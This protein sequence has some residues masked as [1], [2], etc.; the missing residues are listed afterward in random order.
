M[1]LELVKGG[2]ARMAS[3]VCGRVD[4]RSL[5]CSVLLG[6]F[7]SAASAV[8]ILGGRIWPAPDHTRLV[9]DLSAAT[10]YKV[11]TLS[12]PDRV[13]IDV[14]GAQL[15]GRL[16]LDGLEK[17]QIDRIRTAPRGTGDFRVVLD[18][19]RKTAPKSF[20]LQPNQQYGDRLVVDLYDQDKVP[21]DEVVEVVP[22][23]EKKRVDLTEKRDLVIVIDAGHGGEDPGAIGP[24]GVRE[25]NVVLAISKQLDALIDKTPGY[26]GKLTRTGDYYVGL[27]NRT[28]LARKHNA[29]LFVSIHADAFKKPQAKGA[30]V[31]ALSKRG[32]TSET[33]R[34]LAA[35]ENRADLIGGVGGVSLG[36]KDEVLAGVLLDLSMTASMKASLGIGDEVLQSVGR[37]SK[38]HK[39]RVEQAGFVVLKS[40][41]IP[42]ILV[43]TGFISN[44]VESRK[45]NSRK[46]QKRMA[47]AIYRGLQKYFQ[48]NA[49]VGTYVAWQRDRGQDDGLMAYKIQRG[50]TLSEIAKRTRVSVAQLRKIN[51]LSS[52]SI[53]IGQVINIPAS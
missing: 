34:W 37:V 43:E 7:C 27:R 39:K 1:P 25:K 4:W 26:G 21:A 2:L 19:M 41:D 52:D 50:D 28:K 23:V 29:D 10:Q 47:E 35:S 24:G 49:P 11:F 18:V 14:K 44:P 32:A 6:L 45:L 48:V 3:F 42:S 22:D 17:T 16:A 46:Y 12:N 15:K 33:A 5:G 38:L 20:L 8:D 36:D 53:Q 13:V 31:Y 51:G 30:S 9:L 40:P